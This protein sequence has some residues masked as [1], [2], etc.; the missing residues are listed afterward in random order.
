MVDHHTI[1]L[2]VLFEEVFDQPYLFFHPK[3]EMF[4]NYNNYITLYVQ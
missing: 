2:L 4:K 1:I 3:N